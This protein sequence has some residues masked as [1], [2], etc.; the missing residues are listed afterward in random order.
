MN[1]ILDSACSSHMTYQDDVIIEKE[2]DKTEI[3]TVE[4]N[5]TIQS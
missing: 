4:N 3:A 1:W 2:V 5:Q